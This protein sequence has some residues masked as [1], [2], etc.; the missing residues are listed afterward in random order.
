VVLLQGD[1]DEPV[2]AGDRGG[3]R[4]GVLARVRDLVIDALTPEA[5]QALKDASKCVTTRIESTY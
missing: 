1:E 2:E 5:L 4:S 3:P